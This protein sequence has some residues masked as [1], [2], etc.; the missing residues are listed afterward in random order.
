VTGAALQESMSELHT[1]EPHPSSDSGRFYADEKYL[2]HEPRQIQ[3]L[4]RALVDRRCLVTAHPA[5]RDQSFPTALL[6]LDSDN[7]EL[8]LDASPLASINRA[9]ADAPYLLCFAK[10]DRVTVRFRLNQ[11]RP[12]LSGDYVSFRADLPEE[13]YHLQRRELYRLETPVNHSPWCLIPAPEEHLAAIDTRVIDISAGGIALSLPAGPTWLSINQRHEN[14]RLTLP[15]LPEINLTLLVR[16]MR[17]Y[18]LA[19]GLPL[20][21]VGLQI[22]ELP[23]GVETAIQ[24]YIFNVDRQRKAR[25]NGDL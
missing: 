23:R 10:L 3:Q 6:A 1:L 19:K 18:T 14:C 4:M 12:D 20:Q 25:L 24:R 16:N 8:S 5:G 15:E 9:A 22:E 13:V 7:G 21:R 11:I 17:E 2:I